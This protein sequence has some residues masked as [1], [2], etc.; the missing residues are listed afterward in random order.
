MNDDQYQQKKIKIP[1]IRRSRR[2]RI[3]E[4]Q[5]DSEQKKVKKIHY[6]R[7]SIRFITEDDQ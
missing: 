6:E 5:E 1:N 4:D 3:E 7:R 2:F